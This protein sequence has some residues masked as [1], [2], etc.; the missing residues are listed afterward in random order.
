MAHFLYTGWHP[1]WQRDLFTRKEVI[2]GSRIQNTFFV[3]LATNPKTSICRLHK[4]KKK[5]RERE[6]D[7]YIYIY[8]HPHIYIYIS[9]YIYIYIWLRPKT[10]VHRNTLWTFII[11]QSLRKHWPWWVQTSKNGSKRDVSFFQSCSFPVVRRKNRSK[12]STI[13]KLIRFSRS[14][15][16]QTDRIV[17]WCPWVG[18]GA[19]LRK[20]S[21]IFQ[22]D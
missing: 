19:D 22:T 11:P 1:P 4:S 10:P 15:R 9:I 21:T 8:L 2:D 7:I 17:A 13:V 6:R 20:S 14:Q 18:G 5:K 3:M 16:L 12:N